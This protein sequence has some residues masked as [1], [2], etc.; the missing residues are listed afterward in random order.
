MI[1]YKLVVTLQLLL[2]WIV[3]LMVV[4]HFFGD[5]IRNIISK[6]SGRVSGVIPYA[7]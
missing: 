4:Y 6:A 1:L 2:L 5:K 7:K 3:Y